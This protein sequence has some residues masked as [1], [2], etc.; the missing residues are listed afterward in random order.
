MPE[1]DDGL[2]E[3]GVITITGGGDDRLIESWVSQDTDQ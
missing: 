1:E 2:L 3:S